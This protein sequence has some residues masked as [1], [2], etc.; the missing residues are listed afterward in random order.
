MPP[1]TKLR[2]G[3][4]QNFREV[5]SLASVFLVASHW[6]AASETLYEAL[7]AVYAA[8]PGLIAERARQAADEENVRQAISGWLPTVSL[9]ASTG[10]RRTQTEPTKSTTH[11]DPNGLGITLSQP[12]FQ[13]MRTLQGKRKADAEARAGQSQLNGR[14]QTALL[15]G[16]TAYVDVLRD[17]KIL[18]LRTENVRSLQSSL[19]ASLARHKAGDLSKTD[20]AQ[21]RARYHEGRAD[22]SQA[23][24]ELAASEARYRAV[25]GH[26]PGRLSPPQVPEHLLPSSFDD[27][28]AAADAQNPEVLSA[29]SLEQAARHEKLQAWGEMLPTVTLEAKYRTDY[30]HEALVDNEEESSVF[31]RLNMPLYQGGAVRSKIRQSRARESNRRYQ[32]ANTRRQTQA[33][34]TDAWQQLIAAKARIEAARQQVA[35]AREALKGVSVE[36]KVGERA[37]FEILDAQRELV[38]AQVSSARATRD[39]YVA[40]YSVLSATGRLRAHLLNLP[41]PTPPP[42]HLVGAQSDHVTHS[43]NGRP[44]LAQTATRKRQQTVVD[45]PHYDAAQ[46]VFPNGFRTSLAE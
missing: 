12:V 14:E 24:A 37:F 3:P 20:V 39:R 11:L 17:R 26:S 10:T 33:N 1:A 13:G 28:L 41:A 21:A 19:S 7:S 46:G 16:V 38:N 25:V 32:L 22:L 5:V 6:A 35:A 15:D 31:L 23:T 8:N 36:V 4:L 45:Q 27:A 29:R 9:D 42:G 30:G 43:T 40:S 34:V 18:R 2:L 44:P